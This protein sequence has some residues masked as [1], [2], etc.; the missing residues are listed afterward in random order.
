MKKNVKISLFGIP[1]DLGAENLG[2]DT[3]PKALREIGIIKK[4]EKSGL[5]IIDKGDIKVLARKGLKIGSRNLKY[6]DEIIRVSEKTAEKVDSAISLGNKVLAI[7]GDHVISLGTISGAANVLKGDLGII[8]IDTHGD[9]NTDKTTLSGNIHGMHIASVLGFGEKRLVDLYKKG[10]KIKKENIILVGGNDLDKEEINLIEKENIKAF[11]ITNL[12]ANGLNPLFEMINNLNKK[13][14]NVWV[15]LDL[16]VIDYIYA[17]GVGIQNTGGLT[18][19][20]ISTIAKYIGEKCNVVGMD[21]AEYNP[22]KDIDNK[23]AE[24][25]IELCAKIFGFDYSPYTKYMEKN[26]L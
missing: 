15:S 8:Y 24:L 12:L 3:A 14:K 4:L 22:L 26:K 16:D 1:L 6:L 21:L 18:Y 17:P 7:G 2:V 19:R 5:E 11:T 23:T 20:E 9:I 10:R 25:S 13:V